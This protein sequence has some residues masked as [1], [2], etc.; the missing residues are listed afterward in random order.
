MRR[1]VGNDPLPYGLAENLK[2]IQALE[3]TAFKQ[4]LIPRRMAISELFVDPQDR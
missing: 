1:I 2:T 4:G 3:E